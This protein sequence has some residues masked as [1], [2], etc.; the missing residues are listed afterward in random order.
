MG[1]ISVVRDPVEETHLGVVSGVKEVV[2]Q[3]GGTEEGMQEGG[4]YVV[5]MWDGTEKRVAPAEIDCLEIHPQADDWGV[6]AVLEKME[7]HFTGLQFRIEEVGAPDL[8]ENTRR[9]MEKHRA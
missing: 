9:I 1:Y 5:Q 4:R 2:G 8:S 7:E 6:V 3:V